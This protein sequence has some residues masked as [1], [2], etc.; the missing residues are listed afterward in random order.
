GQ[1]RPVGPPPGLTR[2]PDGAEASGSNRS[3]KSSAFPSRRRPTPP[4]AQRRAPGGAGWRP[5]RHG[6]RRRQGRCDNPSGPASTAFPGPGTRP[7][8]RPPAPAGSE[9]TARPSWLEVSARLLVAED[10]PAPGQVVG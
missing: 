6:P 2:W 8:A 3:E 7:T 10:D 9:D 4:G 1:A 5:F